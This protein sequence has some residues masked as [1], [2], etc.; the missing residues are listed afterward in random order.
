MI[1]STRPRLYD[2]NQNILVVLDVS[3]RRTRA[4]LQNDITLR[5]TILHALMI[6]A[7]AVKRLPDQTKAPYPEIAWSKIIG[8]G[9]MIKHEYHRVDSEIVWDGVVDHLKP[10]HEVVKK[11][12]ADLEQPGLPL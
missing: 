3:K 10:L 8:L 12:L 7:E 2:I 5:Y 1:R 9:I 6:I 11:L 4:H